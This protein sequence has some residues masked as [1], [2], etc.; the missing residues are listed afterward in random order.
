MNDRELSFP[1]A[2][3]V[4]RGPKVR[5]DNGKVQ[6]FDSS[7]VWGS[8]Q[9]SGFSNTVTLFIL[10]DSFRQKPQEPLS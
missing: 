2:R 8:G 3:L 5:K 4:V 10:A 1:G 6:R 9:T 7:R